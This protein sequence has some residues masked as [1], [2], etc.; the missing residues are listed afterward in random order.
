MRIL[1]TAALTAFLSISIAPSL[2]AGGLKI[3][4]LKIPTTDDI[5]GELTKGMKI[6]SNVDTDPVK[7]LEKY[8][9]EP[10]K[11]NE[12]YVKAGDDIL[13]VDKR[14]DKVIEVMGSAA[15]LQK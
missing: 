14:N 2:D 4:G 9:L 12:E 8:G 6:P 10:L 5:F 7:N 13:K 1:T 3:P 11:K 15:D